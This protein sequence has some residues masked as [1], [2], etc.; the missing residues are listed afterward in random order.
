[1]VHGK[2]IVY[3]F[4]HEIIERIK[5]GWGKI[6]Q[7]EIRGN[8]IQANSSQ[9]RFGIQKKFLQMYYFFFKLFG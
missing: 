6:G 5:L 4:I 9:T 1:M 7:Y 3:F 8:E 2:K